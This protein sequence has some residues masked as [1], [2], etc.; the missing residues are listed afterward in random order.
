M[1]FQANPQK[2][3]EIEFFA[4][5]PHFEGV[6]ECRQCA[7]PTS[8]VAFEAPETRTTHVHDR[9]IKQVRDALQVVWLIEA[10]RSVVAGRC[11]CRSRP[12]R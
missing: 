2:T 5:G 9:E 3:Q 6:P 1:R 4:A 11:A 12:E 8:V 7:D 10:N